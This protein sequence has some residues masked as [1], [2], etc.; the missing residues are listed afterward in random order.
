M[1]P[2][3]MRVLSVYKVW[4][5]PLVLINTNTG[6][7]R[8]WRGSGEG[9]ENAMQKTRLICIFTEVC[10]QTQQWHNGQCRK[11]LPYCW[12]V[13]C[14]SGRLFSPQTRISPVQHAPIFCERCVSSL[15]PL[16]QTV[17]QMHYYVWQKN[18]VLRFC[19]FVNFSD[20]FPERN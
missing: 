10:W 11:V 9:V 4:V 2:W 19:N 20:T 12:F 18:R 17:S 7:E 3:N 15:K 1:I 14:F 16:S 5:V 13:Y 8:E 6:V